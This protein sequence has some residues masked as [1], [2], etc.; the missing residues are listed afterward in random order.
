MT[1]GDIERR[2]E[3]S[4]SRRLIAHVPMGGDVPGLFDV[5]YRVEERLVRHAGRE[6]AE[7]RVPERFKLAQ[8][9][10]SKQRRH[11]AKYKTPEAG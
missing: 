8:A 11:E 3:A 10:R 6:L 1:I 7:S 2:H 4:L 5:R 9:D